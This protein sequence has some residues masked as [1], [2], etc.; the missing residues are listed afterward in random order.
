MENKPLIKGKKYLNTEP[1]KAADFTK[2]RPIFISYLSRP[3]EAKWVDLQIPVNNFDLNLNHKNDGIS[4]LGHSSLF[5]QLGEVKILMDPVFSERVSFVQWAGPK[6]VHK[7]PVDLS[8]IK[9]IQID[10][11]IL[12]HDHYDHMD[13]LSIKKLSNNISRFIV[14]KGVKAILISWG[15]NSQCISELSWWEKT[16]YKDLEITATPARHFSG[17]GIHNRD[18]TLWSSYVIKN[19]RKKIYFCGDSGYTQWFK[20]IGK[21]M[22]P[23]D[24][25]LMPIGAYSEYWQDIHTNPEEALMGHLELN[26]NQCLPIHWATFDLALHSWKE[27]IVRFIDFAEKKNIEVL[28]PQIGEFINFSEKFNNQNWF[29]LSKK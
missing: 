28:N 8:N 2:I 24:L 10:V 13:Y 15:I 14:P 16:E 3:K 20:E 27:P 12:S 23:F 25:S 6:R 11:L 21:R 17:R 22:G 29:E 19:Q 4:W 5:L 7:S 18:Q 26:A 9:E 1:T